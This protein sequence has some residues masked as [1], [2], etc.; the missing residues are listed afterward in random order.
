MSSISLNGLL[1]NAVTN[2]ISGLRAQIEARAEEATTGFHS[3][4][5]QHL[6]G[7]IDQALLGDQALKDNAD[8]QSRLGLRGIRLS[9]AETTLSSVRGLSEGLQIGMLNAIGT[10]ET[11]TQDLY[12]TEARTALD[13]ILSRFSARHGERFIFSGDATATNPFAD[14]DVLL[15]DIR[16]IAAGALDEAD[17]ATQVD[18]YFTDP[19]GGF[20]TNFYQGAQTAS[21]PDSVLANQQAF[22]DLFQGLAIMSLSHSSESVPFARGDTPAM[23]QALQR[24]ERGR[25]GL[26][27]LEA[28]IGFRQAS[29]DDELTLLQRE[30]TLLNQAFIDLAG[31]DQFEAAA[32]L[33]ELEANLEASYLLTTRLSNL[34]ILN[35]L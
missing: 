33:R 10:A 18:F 20:Q 22:A 15:D 34:S 2:N 4:L 31:K 12:A 8:D 1:N 24:L 23:D 29:I 30:Q 28:G 35:F 14:A 27:D 26:V 3:D 21:D 16:T 11:E 7:R 19:T 32:Q 25:T 5:V 17:F 9:L 6:K 13:D